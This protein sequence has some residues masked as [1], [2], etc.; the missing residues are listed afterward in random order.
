MEEGISKKEVKIAMNQYT[1]SVDKFYTMVSPG[2]TTMSKFMP[3][4]D[5]R[6][7]LKEIMT[8]C[9]GKCSP[10]LPRLSDPPKQAKSRKDDDDG[11]DDDDPAPAPETS[12]PPPAP[13]K[14]KAEPKKSARGTGPAN[15]ADPTGLCTAVCSRAPLDAHARRLHAHRLTRAA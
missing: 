12:A 14:K 1:S 7:K 3:R 11:A 13:E 9:K 15:Q 6:G 8:S 4:L 2:T 10:T 5:G